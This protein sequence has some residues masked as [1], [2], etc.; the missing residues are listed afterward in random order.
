MLKFLVALV[1]LLSFHISFAQEESAREPSATASGATT[2]S[3]TSTAGASDIKLGEA[4]TKK[5]LMALP[6]FNYQGS[7]SGSSHA[8][9]AELFNTINNDLNVSAFFQIIPQKAYLED[10]S[11]TGLRPA[12][13]EPNGFKFQSWGTI[14]AE[15]LIR[16]GF[17]IAG[18]ELNFEAYLYH[19]G[20]SQ[21]IM[22]KKYKGPISGVRKIAHTF[23]NDVLEALTGKTGMFL[24]KIVVSSDK[25][26]GRFKEIYVMDWDGASP[27]KI[28]NHRSIS[29]SPAWSP[30]GKKIAY[31]SYVVRTKTKMRNADMFLYDLTSGKRDLISFRQGLNSGACFAPDNKTI[32][33]TISQQGTPDLYKMSFDGTLQGKI[34][35]GPNNAMNVEPAISSDGTKLAFSSDRSGRPMIYTMNTNGSEV[36]RITFAGVYNSTPSWSPDGKKIAFA[37]QSEDH[38]DIFVMN[39]DGTN[40]IRLTSARKPNGKWSTNEDPSFSP[41]GRFVMYTSNRT[42]KN[43]VF[44]STVDGTEE[45]RVTLDTANY[46]KPKWSNNIE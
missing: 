18:G 32:Y 31:T 45:R 19:V 16:G 15:F 27:E 7:P 36:K 10:T 35:N 25:S 29:L 6:P 39:S 28:S 44:I 3:P 23:S 12:P 33:L 11:K 5:S 8:T 21:L 41:D 1:T 26:G 20:K 9:G 2:T 40:M 13:G 43:Q 42:G 30:D 46:F 17:F 4:H 22:G 38:F 34:T 14:G 37:G 24:S